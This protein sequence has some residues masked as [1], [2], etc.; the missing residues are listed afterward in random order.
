MTSSLYIEELE[1]KD[2]AKKIIELDDNIKL[3]EK[4]VILVDKDY[5]VDA[6]VTFQSLVESIIVASQ[7]LKS[8]ITYTAQYSNTGD[9]EE[10]VFTYYQTTDFFN[11]IKAYYYKL[12]TIDGFDF[13]SVRIEDF[14]NDTTIELRNTYL[15]SYSKYKSFVAQSTEYMTQYELREFIK[16]VEGIQSLLK[17]DAVAFFANSFETSPVTFATDIELE[18]KSFT[19][20][21][22]QDLINFNKLSALILNANLIRDE[23]LI[24]LNKSITYYDDLVVLMQKDIK[25]VILNNTDFINEHL[26][27]FFEDYKSEIVAAFNREDYN[28]VISLQ[29]EFY[30]TSTLNLNMFTAL[31]ILTNNVSSIF[32]HYINAQNIFVTEQLQSKPV[33]SNNLDIEYIDYLFEDNM[34][35]AIRQELSG[36]LDNFYLYIIDKNKNLKQFLLNEKKLKLSYFDNSSIKANYIR[37]YNKIL[38]IN[39]IYSVELQLISTNNDYAQTHIINTFNYEKQLET[40]IMHQN[41]TLSSLSKT[42]IEQYIDENYNIDM[43]AESAINSITIF[44]ETIEPDILLFESELLKYR[45][46]QINKNLLIEHTTIK[47]NHSI[48][49]SNII[50]QNTINQIKP[51]SYNDLEVIKGSVP[52]MIEMSAD[53]DFVDGDLPIFTWEINGEI[54]EGKEIS[55]TIYTEGITRVICSRIYPSGE[56]TV[57]YVEFD[58]AGPTNSQVVKSTSVEY[59]PIADYIN[60]PMITIFD[61]STNTQVTIPITVNGDIAEM[62]AD[63]NISVSES[64]SD[65]LIEKAGLVMLGFEGIE[66]AGTEFDYKQIFAE[67]FEMPE[68]ADFLFDFQVS[69]PVANKSVID[70]SKSS[71]VVAMAKVPSS[72]VSSVYDISDVR[73]YQMHSGTTLPIIVGDIIIMKNTSNRYALIEIVSI[74]SVT[75]A[76]LGKYNFEIEFDVHVNVS[77]NQFE[78]TNFRPLTTNYVVPTLIFETNS[79]ELFSSLIERIEKINILQLAMDETIDT[80]KKI[81]YTEEINEIKFINNKF[82]LFS[83]YNKLSAKVGMLEE[84]L[85]AFNMSIDYATIN[86]HDIILANT[87]FSNQLN[88]TKTFA[89]YMNDTQ[90]YDFRNNIIDLSIIVELYQEEQKML[91]II[92]S[93]FDYMNKNTE[94]FVDAF[95]S[96]KYID[97]LLTDKKQYENISYIEQLPMIVKN[98]RIHLYRLKLAIN[99]PILITGKYIIP[100]SSFDRPTYSVSG[101][102]TTIDDMDFYLLNKKIE[103]AFGYETKKS[104]IEDR[105][106]I[107][108]ITT[109]VKSYQGTCLSEN[110]RT[111]IGKYIEEVERRTVIEYDDFFMLPFWMDYLTKLM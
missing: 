108:D 89:E 40:L 72:K 109:L 39:E 55:Y 90:L 31:T 111:T 30:K 104:L 83:E 47:A 73:E 28:G 12:M 103:L 20:K 54:L 46:I 34:L 64:D 88:S 63:G 105:N 79:K 53:F 58:I 65:L 100:N 18:Y 81:I 92:L 110:E 6:D 98:A 91:E 78:Q 29:D 66:I 67:D 23:A 59:S 49:W 32:D 8:N 27:H 62:I 87:D 13:N 2:F 48:S 106:L 24:V 16:Q 69:D 80:E 107:T 61:S 21:L 93:T 102:Q 70:I 3:L 44:N 9:K 56:T 5:L 52:F 86:T 33:D 15:I 57:R 71:F 85:E 76:E 41:D 99:L 17:V 97:P 75:D 36:N 43:I 7:K 10:L 38:A 14:G 22:S 37:L 95:N 19:T 94:Y 50:N 1:K 101:E 82:Y 96:C 45:E 51:I 74:S 60:Q 35:E 84:K 42:I 25:Y 11:S 68:E 77:L 4:G 26:L